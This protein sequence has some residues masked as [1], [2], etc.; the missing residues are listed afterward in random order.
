[1]TQVS[2][3]FSLSHYWLLLSCESRL[4]S[5]DFIF[6]LPKPTSE[7]LHTIRCIHITCTHPAAQRTRVHLLDTESFDATFGP[8]S[9]R[10]RPRISAPDIEVGLLCACVPVYCVPMCLS[11]VC[12]C[13]GVLCAY[14]PV[15]CVPACLCTCVL[16]AC[17]QCACVLCTILCAVCCVPVCCVPVCCV[18]VYYE[19]V[20]NVPVCLCACVLCACVL[21]AIAQHLM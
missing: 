4:L 21:C 20:Y 11:A 13:A 12:L 8:K 6:S 1:M 10:K 3:C 17:V 19:P 14:V 16:W 2:L 9:Q 7:D 5:L 18:P 15:C